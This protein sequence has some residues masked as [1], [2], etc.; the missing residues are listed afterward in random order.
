MREERVFTI[1][2]RTAKDLDDALSIKRLP[3]GNFVVGVHI[4]DVSFFVKPDTALDCEANARATTVYLVQRNYP[5]VRE[6]RY[7]TVVLL[8][9][10][11]MYF[12]HRHA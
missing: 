6:T 3:D 9:V 2:P 8:G 10:I 4:A 1:D 5:M 11:A 7:I 12:S